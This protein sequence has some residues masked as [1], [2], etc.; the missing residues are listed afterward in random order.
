[1]I[2]TDESKQ[3]SLENFI[4]DENRVINSLR[5]LRDKRIYNLLSKQELSIN[6]P[7]VSVALKSIRL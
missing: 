5:A 7:L 2:V 3:L 4:M 6:S 1:M